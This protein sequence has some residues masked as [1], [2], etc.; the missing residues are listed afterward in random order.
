M[1]TTKQMRLNSG[2]AGNRKSVCGFTLIELLVVIA[3]IAILAALLLPALAQAR[4]QGKRISCISNLKQ[5]AMIDMMYSTDY[6]QLLAPSLIR[7]TDCNWCGIMI[8]LGYCKQPML[9]STDPPK[10]ASGLFR[11]PSGIDDKTSSGAASAADVIGGSDSQRPYRGR[12]W[13]T[14][15]WDGSNKYVFS[16][17]MPNASSIDNANLPRWRVAPDNHTSDW[18]RYASTNKIRSTSQ[19]VM[20]SDGCAP[21]NPYNGYRI[22]ARHMSRRITN[23]AFFDGHCSA[24]NTMKELPKSGTSNWSA[25]ALNKLNPN[26][27]WLVTQ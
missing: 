14:N 4:E 22:A 17:Y 11:C 15:N 27:K 6:N 12:Q 8:G 23:L 3:I 2:I 16:W 24:A 21:D 10:N 5:I 7:N 9:K 13:G 20:F 19:T 1:Y 25:S 26:I 18:T